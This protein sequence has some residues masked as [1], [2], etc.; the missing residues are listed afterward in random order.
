M[1]SA[2]ST[3]NP[4]EP[5]VQ[6]ESAVASQG[7]AR[8]HLPVVG[9]AI[10]SLCLG[11]GVSSWM[12][13]TRSVPASAP[14]AGP[15]AAAAYNGTASIENPLAANYGVWQVGDPVGV[16]AEPIVARPAGSDVP[17]VVVVR[18]AVV[19]RPDDA[20]WESK[21]NARLERL[22]DAVTSELMETPFAE[23]QARGYKASLASQL[24]VR[25]SKIS[26]LDTIQ[27]VLIP[28]FAVQ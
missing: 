9:A 12:S 23:M 25:F 6:P 7:G 8:R 28:M 14:A 26:G 5:A 16:G 2:S 15:G 21:V 22:R 18:V 17:Y 3:P 24:K 4:P 19:G 10:V 1:A 20:R 13:T 27:E 11:I